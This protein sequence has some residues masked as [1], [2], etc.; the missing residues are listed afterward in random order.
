MTEW[1]SRRPKSPHLKAQDKPLVLTT[2]EPPVFNWAQV[3]INRRGL[4]QGMA[5]IIF[6]GYICIYLS[7]R[8]S[9]DANTG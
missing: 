5:K 6:W 3:L 2:Y 1:H 4:Y 9:I 8:L 7:R